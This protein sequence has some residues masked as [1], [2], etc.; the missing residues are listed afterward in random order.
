ML[1]KLFLI[2][3][4]AIVLSATPALA[5]GPKLGDGDY[6]VYFVGDMSETMDLHQAAPP[7][8]PTTDDFDRLARLDDLC[9]TQSKQLKPSA[10]KSVFL[11]TLRG[12]IPSTLLGVG[13]AALGGFTNSTYTA[14]NYAEYI[15]GG[16]I[17]G[18]IGGGIN[19]Y[20]MAKHGQIAGCMM[21]LLNGAQRLGYLRNV[22]ITYNTFPVNGHAI[23]RANMAQPAPEDQDQPAGLTSDGAD[24]NSAPPPP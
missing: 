3:A 24:Y 7:P 13:G 23:K 16:V 19:A 4:G 20:E 5:K 14:G 22:V 12:A 11:Y 21:G 9:R 15:G 10:F 6:F 1:K 18:G 8:Q 17:G 2:L